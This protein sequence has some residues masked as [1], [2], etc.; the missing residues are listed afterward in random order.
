LLRLHSPPYL[1][2]LWKKK[3]VSFSFSRR[4][5]CAVNVLSPN[6]DLS[7]RPRTVRLDLTPPEG[8]RPVRPQGPPRRARQKRGGGAAP[9][10]RAT[11]PAAP[12]V[13]PARDPTRGRPATRGSIGLSAVGVTAPFHY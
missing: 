13:G 4:C 5:T 8:Q 7:R 9:F 1:Y 10:V 11:P 3:R 2:L 12:G 6:D